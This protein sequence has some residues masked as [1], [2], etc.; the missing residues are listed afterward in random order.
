MIRHENHYHFGD[1]RL[2][3][4]KKLLWTL[5]IH[6]AISQKLTRGIHFFVLISMMSIQGLANS[7]PQKLTISAKNER[8]QAVLK[9]IEQQTGYRFD[10]SN[11][12]IPATKRITLNVKEKLDRT[13]QFA[14]D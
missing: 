5:N 1:Q 14:I 6:V 11:I 9:S 2:T 3:N 8:L 13:K 4:Q 12:I 7:N 10:Y